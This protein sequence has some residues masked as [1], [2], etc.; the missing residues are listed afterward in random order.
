MGDLIIIYT[1]LDMVRLELQY[2]NCLYCS[3]Q[4]QLKLI[5]SMKLKKIINT[6]TSFFFFFF[7]GDVKNNYYI[8]NYNHKQTVKKK[9]KIRERERRREAQKIY[10]KKK[11]C[12]CE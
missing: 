6:D 2:L 8:I 11:R 3:D 10:L 5:S 4:V 7:G 9:R 12:I 1:L